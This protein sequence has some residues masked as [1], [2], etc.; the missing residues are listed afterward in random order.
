MNDRRLSAKLVPTFADREIYDSGA[1][2]NM[3]L[4]L[5]GTQSV[6]GARRSVLVK[7]LYYKSESRGF[8][9]R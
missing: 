6:R 3:K 4:N 1:K 9:T 8:E 5:E 2:T 7:V